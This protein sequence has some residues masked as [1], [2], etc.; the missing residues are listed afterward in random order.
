MVNAPKRESTGIEGLDRILGGLHIGD[1]V[2]WHDDAGSL[3]APFGLNLMLTARERRLPVVYVSFDRSPK[4]LIDKLGPLAEMP[5]LTV[6]DCFTHGK[7]AGAEVFQLFYRRRK[8]PLP[9]LVCVENPRDPRRFTQA[10]Y[11][12]IDTR[13]RGVRLIFESLTGM[14]ELWGGEERVGRFYSHACPRL[15]ELNTIAYWFIEKRAHSP[16]F[17]AGLNQIAQVVIDLAVKRGKTSLTILKAEKQTPA[18]LNQPMAYWTLE[19]RI[20]FA[21][22]E[23][24]PAPLR[25]GQRLKSLRRRRGLSQAEVARLIGVT[26]SSISQI[27]GNRIYPSLPALLR[28]A[29]IL[30]VGAASLLEAPRR[31][32]RAVVFR[33]GDAT[34]RALAGPAAGG[35]RAARLTPPDT[36][37]AAECLLIEFPP[38]FRLNRHFT[39]PKKP[40]LGHVLSGRLRLMIGEARHSAEAGDT[41]S[42]PQ[43]APRRWENPGPEPARLL[44]VILA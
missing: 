30:G 2:I 40:E 13:G 29:E 5:T 44:W 36:E 4:N 20:R 41:I 3:A 9:R 14:Q 42:L 12:T 21:A 17:K 25:L 33:P 39:E 15:Y 26:A 38:G 8:D 1:N 34:V 24:A 31:A 10:L 16:R 6:L 23:R 22:E 27:E 18:A 43:E 11:R 35:L 19:N 7:G 32:E 28:L 37:L